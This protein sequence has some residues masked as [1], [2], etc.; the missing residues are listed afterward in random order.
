MSMRSRPAFHRLHAVATAE[1]LLFAAAC[2]YDYQTDDVPR[3]MGETASADNLAQDA[4]VTLSSASESTTDASSPKEEPP[5]ADDASGPTAEEPPAEEL[6]AGSLPQAI[7]EQFEPLSDPVSPYELAYCEDEEG[8]LWIAS[9]KMRAFEGEQVVLETDFEPGNQGLHCM[10]DSAAMIS[11]RMGETRVVVHDLNARTLEAAFD[12]QAWGAAVGP[13]GMTLL[14]SQIP[15]Q[16]QPFFDDSQLTPGTGM[17]LLALDPQLQLMWI[18]GHSMEGNLWQS[19]GSSAGF[20]YVWQTFDGEDDVLLVNHFAPDGT[21]VRRHCS[22]RN[23]WEPAAAGGR[24]VF[25]VARWTEPES[26]NSYALLE[27]CSPEPER[28]WAKAL[29]AVLTDLQL[30]RTLALAPTNDGGVFLLGLYQQTFTLGSIT[31]TG[32]QTLSGAY[33]DAF[34]A[35]FD[36]AGELSRLDSIGPSDTVHYLDPLWT[37]RGLLVKV[38]PWERQDGSTQ[39][40]YAG[41]WKPSRPD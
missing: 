14:F 33:G 22:R 23:A 24:D 10:H 30:Q 29:P 36:A 3:P 27:R 32:D 6:P 2:D 7:A 12:A 38:Q 13:T 21:F 31:L 25:H 20:S 17:S 19:T 11:I 4:G 8:R 41:L 39:P 18:R 9:D 26:G 1:L 34:I 5:S 37:S 16:A 35:A 28:R 15:T 40:A